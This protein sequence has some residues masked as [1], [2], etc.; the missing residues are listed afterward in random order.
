MFK[1]YDTVKQYAI[2][3]V[4]TILIAIA[5]TLFF[6]PYGLVTGGVTGLSI[7]FAELA[8]QRGIELRLWML[9]LILNFPL[10]LLGFKIFGIKFLAKSVYATLFLS[11]TLYAAEILPP[12]SVDFFL[13]AVF[14]G[15]LAG[16]GL[17]LVFRCFATTGGT[18][19]AATIIHKYVKQYS[20]AKILFSIDAVIVLVGMVVFGIIE[21]MYAIVAIYVASKTIDAMLEG[22]AFGKAG[23]IISDKSEEIGQEILSVLDR[24]VTI[25]HGKGMY[26]GND[27]NILLCVVSKKQIV[28][29]KELTYKIDQKAFIIVTD[30]REV[31]GEGF[32]TVKK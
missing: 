8:S 18:D 2:I 3:S 22:L 7:V 10:F 17:G 28:R 12:I 24:G 25:L 11:F 31:L 30:V 20:V 6:R 29:L 14:G 19:L 9:N 4:G 15:A 32:Q 5:L 1:Q 21:V 13:A 16:I 23:F 27:K 26:T